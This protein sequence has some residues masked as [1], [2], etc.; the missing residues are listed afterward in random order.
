MDIIFV[1][2]HGNEP[3]PFVKPALSRIFL[4]RLGRGKAMLIDYVLKKPADH[5][6]RNSFSGS[7]RVKMKMRAIRQGYDRKFASYLDRL[8]RP[9]LKA[10]DKLFLRD[11]E[12]WFNAFPEKIDKIISHDVT[13]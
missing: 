4:R 6:K 9:S 1:I 13:G 2:S 8:Y 3:K 5:S 12:R 11:V 10:T 7:Q